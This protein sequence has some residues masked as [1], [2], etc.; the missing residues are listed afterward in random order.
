MSNNTEGFIKQIEGTKLQVEEIN[1]SVA[2]SSEDGAGILY[3]GW[4]INNVA[5][6]TNA[7]YGFIFGPDKYIHPKLSTSIFGSGDTAQLIIDF[8]LTQF[9]YIVE[10]RIQEY[11]NIDSTLAKDSIF[12]K[13]ALLSE[14]I[15]LS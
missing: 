1:A 9:E 4:N 12:L 14:I 11:A 13:S 6:P 15:F 7:R 8:D 3:K 2:F 10:R 5:S